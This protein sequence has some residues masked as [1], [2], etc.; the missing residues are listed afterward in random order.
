VSYL[1]GALSVNSLGEPLNLYLKFK[2]IPG[3]SFKRTK[4]SR[5]GDPI[6]F[7]SSP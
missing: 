1:S 2:K 5:E 3:F 7:T 4:E 6:V